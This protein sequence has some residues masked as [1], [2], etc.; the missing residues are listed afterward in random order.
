MYVYTVENGKAIPVNNGPKL[1]GTFT[2]AFI[3]WDGTSKPK[4]RL[5]PPRGFR[6]SDYKTESKSPVA[7][8][9]TIPTIKLTRLEDLNINPDLF[10]PLPA[11]TVFDNLFSNDGGILPATNIFAVGAPGIGK[12]TVLLD[13][14]AHLHNKGK[15]V[16]FISAEMNEMDLSRYLKRFPHWAQLP[17]LFLN[18]YTENS[19]LVIEQVL[20]EGW[21]VVLTDSFTE[22]NDHVKEHT[23][24]TRGR[25]ENWFISL[26][27]S[28]NKAQSGKHTSFITIL[29]ISK[30]GVFVGG[31][32]LKHMATAMMHLD[33]D[34]GENGR[35]YI[36]FSKNRVGAVN[37][38]LFF[39]FNDGVTF[40]E[41]RYKHDLLNDEMLEDERA[42]LDN[43]GDSFDR[44]FGFDK[45][46]EPVETE[47][48][49]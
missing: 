47:E 2:K 18:N 46:D 5:G 22:T 39:N 29:Q 13:H 17:I 45:K 9:V 33:W 20:S 1:K 30:G 14:L 27:D 48:N 23:G 8:Q 31:N 15:K 49:S 44:L 12:T 16:L 36:Q 21:D 26:M 25:T 32:R 6:M 28:H 34:G 7:K 40:N 19:N 35:R 10:I 41:E 24:W 38:K 43:E 42:Q 11:G 3:H 4:E 37:K